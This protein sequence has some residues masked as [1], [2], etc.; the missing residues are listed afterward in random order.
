MWRI[1]SQASLIYHQI[2]I[3]TSCIVLPVCA[4][5]R[6]NAC[7]YLSPL[8]QHHGLFRDKASRY[9]VVKISTAER[10]I[11]IVFLYFVLLGAVSLTSFSI[12]RREV[13]SF[14][15]NISLYFICERNGANPSCDRGSFE[16]KAYP[17][18]ASL[19]HALLSL[20]PAINLIYVISIKDALLCCRGKFS[21]QCCSNR[22]GTKTQTTH[23][24][25]W[26][27][28]RTADV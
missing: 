3:I 6:L 22:V 18:L 27:N 13:E 4:T 19:T 28:K 14:I 2:F 11:L 9:P 8:I 23:R 5:R 16:N 10:K 24:V 25:A 1:P 12:S 15:R 26:T 20:F 17:E 7:N 21:N